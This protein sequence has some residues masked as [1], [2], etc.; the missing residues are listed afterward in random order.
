MAGSLVVVYRRSGRHPT[1][2]ACVGLH[3][4]SVRMLC[5]P[6]ARLFGEGRIVKQTI[7]LL[8]VLRAMASHPR[9][10]DSL[11]ANIWECPWTSVMGPLATMD[12]LGRSFRPDCLVRASVGSLC[13]QRSSWMPGSEASMRSTNP[14]S[15]IRSWQRKGC[16]KEI[17]IHI[18]LYAS[19]RPRP[20]HPI[21]ASL[22]ADGV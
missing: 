1:R 19:S 8:H 5:R 6:C 3:T 22:P 14:H 20:W 15:L 12:T 9:L 2:L 21:R 18:R 13:S 7:T 11:L 16:K 10:S 4:R 17:V